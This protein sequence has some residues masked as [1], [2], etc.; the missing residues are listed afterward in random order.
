MGSRFVETLAG[1]PADTWCILR[2][3]GAAT[4]RLA[5]SLTDDGLEAWSPRETRKIRIPR[6][7]VRRD[8]V[9]PLLPSYVFAKAS[10]L[11]ELL[12][13]SAMPIKPR[14][15]AQ[16]EASHA[17]FS[18]M[19]CFG[20]LPLVADT[21]LNGLRSLEAKLTPRKKAEH[22]FPEGAEVKVESGSFGGMVGCVKRSDRGQTLVCF[23][24][25]YTVKIS[26]SLLLPSELGVL[27]PY[28][29]NAALDAA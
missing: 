20:K 7:N 8:V 16:S 12:Q 3:R 25:K 27:L 11:V 19:H 1:I 17:D 4:L 15:G 21:D 24:E 26:T 9:L 22:S 29:G 6:M 2:C 14:R 28:D 23:N 13:L 18:V 10:Q 5:E